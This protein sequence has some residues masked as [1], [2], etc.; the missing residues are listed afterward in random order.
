MN[1]Q[2]LIDTAKSLVAGDK[3]LL[4]MDENNSTCKKRFASF[5]IPQTEGVRCDYR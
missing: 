4:S 2:Q 1:E 3:G 5:G